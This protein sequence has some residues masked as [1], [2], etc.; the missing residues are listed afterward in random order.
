MFSLASMRRWSILVAVIGLA[1]AAAVI[2][3]VHAFGAGSETV[4]PRAA[5]PNWNP[6][7]GTVAQA[8]ACGLTVS[9]LTSTKVM[10]DGGTVY[11]YQG[12][13][14]APIVQTVPPKGLNLLTA[15]AAELALYGLTPEPLATNPIAR[16]HW[17]REVGSIKSSV[18]PPPFLYS[19]S[20]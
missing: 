13:E 5:N 11:V 8:E 1:L 14:G 6:Y 2:V 10:P 4:C 7:D 16:A 19:T 17:I 3:S 15:S 18:S 12:P 20:G 9:P